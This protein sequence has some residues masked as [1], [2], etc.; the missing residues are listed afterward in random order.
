MRTDRQRHG[1]Q[2]RCVAHA[3]AGVSRDQARERELDRVGHRRGGAVA[4]ADGSSRGSGGDGEIQHG[5][6][7]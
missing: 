6:S 2:D 4:V 3:R 7:V 5:Q 1:T